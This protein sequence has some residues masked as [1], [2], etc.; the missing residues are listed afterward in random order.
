MRGPLECSIL[1]ISF[2]LECEVQYH[3][4]GPVYTGLHGAPLGRLRL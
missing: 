2:N 3:E 1:S 4:Y